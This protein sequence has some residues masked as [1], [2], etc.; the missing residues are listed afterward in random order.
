M[1]PDPAQGARI[2]H[3]NGRQDA[4]PHLRLTCATRAE[5]CFSLGLVGLERALAVE[6]FF[7]DSAAERRRALF[8]EPPPLVLLED[9]AFGRVHFFSLASRA[10]MEAQSSS[11]L[12]SLRPSD[13]SMRMAYSSAVTSS[14]TPGEG[15]ARAVAIPCVTTSSFRWARTERP[16]F[17]TNQALAPATSKAATVNT[18]SMLSRIDRKSTR[19]NSSHITISYAVFCL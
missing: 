11:R 16:V 4:R 2:L 9:G 19:L 8:L 14:G 13:M 12:K 18:C 6:E 15:C 7:D 17:R 3:G 5:Y 10:R 1:A